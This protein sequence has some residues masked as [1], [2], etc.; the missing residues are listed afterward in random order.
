M[1]SLK[2]YLFQFILRAHVEHIE[3]IVTMVRTFNEVLG[4]IHEVVQFIRDKQSVK[5][6][7]HFLRSFEHIP[8]I[9]LLP[10]WVSNPLC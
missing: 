6:Y 4:T 3:H 7:K 2:L 9:N 10:I 8:E 1:D 5:I